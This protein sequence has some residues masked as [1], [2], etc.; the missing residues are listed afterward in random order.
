MAD[1]EIGGWRDLK[2]GVRLRS[3]RIVVVIRRPTILAVVAAALASVAV[4]LPSP[5][6]ADSL[7]PSYTLTVDHAITPLDSDSGST[8]LEQS[9]ADAKQ[10]Q[11]D[12]EATPSGSIPKVKTP[13]IIAQI[14][15]AGSLQQGGASTTTSGNPLTFSQAAPT[16]GTVGVVDNLLGPIQS[17][18]SQYMAFALFGE[19]FQPGQKIVFSLTD[20]NLIANPPTFTAVDSDGNPDSSIHITLNPKADTKGTSTAT[21]NTAV[22]TTT[23]NSAPDVSVPEPLSLALWSALTGAGL[24]RARRLRHAPAGSL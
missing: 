24:W 10:Y 16:Y 14:V 8:T 13:Q 12:V 2:M 23:Q 7:P 11:A 4:Y 9:M 19:P 6:G 18:N 21:D 22:T 15:P 3:W 1:A 20:P 5:A 17:G